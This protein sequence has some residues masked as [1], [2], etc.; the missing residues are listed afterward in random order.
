MAIAARG[1]D[2]VATGQRKVYLLC[3]VAA[4]VAAGGVG[5]TRDLAG[6]RANYCLPTTKSFLGG[7][8]EPP[9]LARESDALPV[10]HG[11][12]VTSPGSVVC[13]RPDAAALKCLRAERF[14][15]PTI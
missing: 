6:R 7:G 1:G 13:T 10:W 9:T 15:L 11:L 8:F 12:A 14:E 5:T 3:L 2:L 4:C